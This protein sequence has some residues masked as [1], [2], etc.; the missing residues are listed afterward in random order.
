MPARSANTHRLIPATKSSPQR[1]ENR[2]IRNAQITAVKPLRKYK[3]F[4]VYTVSLND[5][6]AV[7]TAAG[8]GSEKVAA[9][10]SRISP[11]RSPVHATLYLSEHGTVTFIVVLD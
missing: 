7:N 8:Y 2:P 6:T 3:G 5:G 4:Q 9:Q 11:L 1:V 10:L